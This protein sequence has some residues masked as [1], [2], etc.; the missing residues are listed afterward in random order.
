MFIL[1]YASRQ[2]F[3]DSDE[4]KYTYYEEKYDCEDDAARAYV[5]ACEDYEYCNQKMIEV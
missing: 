3:D 1:T 5:R 2:W 4:V